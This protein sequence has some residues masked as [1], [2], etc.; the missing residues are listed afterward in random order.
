MT[1][2]WILE[3]SL[4]NFSYLLACVTKLG[5]LDQEKARIKTKINEK[6]LWL[7][8]STFCWFRAWRKLFSNAA[9]WRWFFPAFFFLLAC[10]PARSGVSPY[11]PSYIK[12]FPSFL[13]L[14]LALNMLIPF[15]FWATAS[16]SPRY[17]LLCST[18]QRGAGETY[19]ADKFN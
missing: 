6:T 13:K 17:A 5:V 9:D 12:C 16:F 11:F 8:R 2:N 10:F 15:L 14:W 18:P 19:T 1:C 4:V 3:S 7:I